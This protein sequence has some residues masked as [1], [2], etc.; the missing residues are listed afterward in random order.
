M[1]QSLRYFR[2]KRK[3]YLFTFFVGI[4]LIHLSQFQSQNSLFDFS[5]MNTNFNNPTTNALLPLETLLVAKDATNDI[6]VSIGSSLFRKLTSFKVANSHWRLSN[7]FVNNSSEISITSKYVERR[8]NEHFYDPRITLSV[9]LHE[10][11]ERYS[12]NDDNLPFSWE[13]WV[14]LSYLNIYLGDSKVTC[15]EFYS[16]HKITAPS[17]NSNIDSISDFCIDDSEFLGTEPGQLKNPKLLPGFN[18]K[19]RIDMKSNFVSKTYNAKSFLLSYAEPPKLIYFLN[20]N[21]TYYRARPYPS[22][23]MIENGMLEKFMGTG[24]DMYDPISELKFI[25]PKNRISLDT[26]FKN[27]L[28]E[29]ST[30]ELDIPESK[31]VLDPQKQFKNLYDARSTLDKHESDFLDSLEYSLMM[32]PMATPKY[33]KEVNLVWPAKY[34][35]HKLVEN[36]GHYDARFFS[37]L[38]T[39]MPNSEV[40]FHSPWCE[41]QS[42][43]KFNDTP[44]MRKNSIL[45]HMMHTLL[46]VTFHNGLFMF[47]AHGSLL[48]WYFTGTTFPWDSDGD[49]QMPIADLAEFCLRFNN[50]MIVQNPKYGVSK[51][52]V[53]CTS[54]LTHRIKAN[55]NNNI[56]ARVID[57]DSGLFVDITGLSVSGE[58]LDS[59]NWISIN[60][61]LPRKFRKEYPMLASPKAFN[62]QRVRPLNN[63]RNNRVPK[64][65]PEIEKKVLEVHR[66]Y[67][68]YNCRNRHYYTHD[69][70]SP[71]RLTMFEGAPTFVVASKKSVRAQLESEYKKSSMTSPAWDQWLFSKYLRLWVSAEDAYQILKDNDIEVFKKT[72]K[73]KKKTVSKK[74]VKAPQ[75]L[76]AFLQ[77]EAFVTS[78]LIKKSVYEITKEPVLTTNQKLKYNLIDGIYHDMEVTSAHYREMR[79]FNSQWEWKTPTVEDFRTHIPED[80]ADLAKWML[81]DHAPP[82]MPLLDYLIFTESERETMG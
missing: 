11:K 80:W 51:Y 50:S 25:D 70:L 38:I 76:P 35:N 75:V 30:F 46:S 41:S 62:A 27:I 79:I 3:Y 55:G 24:K 29:K 58:L 33:F 48:G 7:K 12:E 66:K 8:K 18:F 6:L 60:E 67:N 78:E 42:V 20:E 10:L 65:D 63:M 37:G 26:D 61:W 52:Y 34:N 36:G 32:D 13:D 69:Q 39:E 74:N 21:G 9:Y 2:F 17:K 47:P 53:D 54:T 1:W 45:S 64:R 31:F 22:K 16:T 28:S 72:F 59:Q 68:I 5:H 4:L 44:T 57:V 71:V 19:G 81:E 77:N 14:D 23:S 73:G 49:V 15:D 40:T 82:K 43:D 56:D